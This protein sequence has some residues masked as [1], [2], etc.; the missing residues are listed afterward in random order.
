MAGAVIIAHHGKA[1]SMELAKTVREVLVSEGVEVWAD[2]KTA[3]TLGVMPFCWEPE[4]ALRLDS[5]IVLGGD[6][7][8]LGVARNAMVYKLPLMG[9]NLGHVGYLAEVHEGDPKE[10]VR[11][12]ARGEYSLDERTMV[13]TE[14]IRDGRVI[15]ELSGLNDVV[16]NKGSMSRLITLGLYIGDEYLGSFP[17]DGIIIATPTG[18]TA[19]SLSAGGP[20]LSPDLDV[21][22]ATFICPHVLFSRS[23][24]VKGDGKL[25][26]VVEGCT[27]QAVMTV[28]GQVPF[29]ISVGD[30]LRA[31]KSVYTTLFIRLRE[32]NFY[33][34]LK[35]RLKEGRL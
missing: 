32:R 10:A 4:I 6:G 29:P 19:Y 1:N 18:S 23:I 35:E 24:V 28:D 7:T 25:R 14:L 31:K 8:L 26:V 2:E 13:S 16:V 11:K 27:E 15:A 17:G 20:L 12:L 21:L 30:E 9:I 3:S 33:G 34:I 22:V 5:A